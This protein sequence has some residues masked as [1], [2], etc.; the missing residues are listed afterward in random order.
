[1]LSRVGSALDQLAA[2]VVALAVVALPVS[3]HFLGHTGHDLLLLAGIV[4]A[5]A[6]VALAILPGGQGY[7]ET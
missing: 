2:A 3:L 5:W 7:C 4:L 1:M 6:L